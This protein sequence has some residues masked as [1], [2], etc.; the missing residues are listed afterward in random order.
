MI[1]A[2]GIDIVDISRIEGICGKWKR[3]FLERVYSEREIRYC[4]TKALPAQHYAAR[5]AAKEAFLK[6][7]GI[8]IG[9]GVNLKDVEVVNDK[10]GKPELKIRGKSRKI[11]SSDVAKNIHVSISHTDKNAVAVVIIEER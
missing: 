6:C 3:R 9:G 10:K 1:R 7:L 5:F 4:E 2:V 8:G 11:V